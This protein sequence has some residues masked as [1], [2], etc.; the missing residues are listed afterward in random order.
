MGSLY[1]YVFTQKCRNVAFQED[2]ADM[3]LRFGTSSEIQNGWQPYC[4][5]TA[6]SAVVFNENIASFIFE[7]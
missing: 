5:S 6:A 4:W 1:L 7:K 2:Q 3:M